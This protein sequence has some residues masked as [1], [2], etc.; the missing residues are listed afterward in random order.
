MYCVHAVSQALCEV[1]DNKEL[2]NNF[3][4]H[5]LF[6]EVSKRLSKPEGTVQATSVDGTYKLVTNAVQ[7]C[8][9]RVMGL[10]K[11]FYFPFRN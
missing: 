2:T 1:L 11:E 3:N 4:I 10:S 5:T 7:G 6:S 9:Y 8:E